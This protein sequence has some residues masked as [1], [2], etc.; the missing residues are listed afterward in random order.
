MPGE[1]DEWN[2][3]YEENP[4]ASLPWELGRPRKQLIEV[5]QKGKMKRGK[6]LDICCD[7]RLRAWTFQAGHRI[8]KGK[9]KEAKVE[10]KTVSLTSCLTWAAS[11]IFTLK[12][13]KLISLALVE[14]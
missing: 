5:V 7:L 2:R 14:F 9:S 1:Y 4:L 11:T 10:M 6:A 3:I 8:C 12:T 13:A